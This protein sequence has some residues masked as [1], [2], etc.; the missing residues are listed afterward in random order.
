MKLAMTSYGKLDDPCVVLIHPFPFSSEMLA[1][2]A[3]VLAA[4][5]FRVI[6]PDLP[7]FGRTPLAQIAP[8]FEALGA[9]I[10]DLLDELQVKK[11][12]VG[13]V[14]LGGYVA[15]SVLRQFS[16]RV[17]GLLLVDTKA[18]ADSTEARENRLRIA[19]QM[20]EN[21]RLGLFAQQMLPNLISAESLAA[22]PGLEFAVTAHIEASDPLA[23][24]WMQEAM[25]MRPDSTAD[26]AKVQI[27]VLLLRGSAD[28]LCSPQDYQLMIDACPAAQF[29]ELVEIGHLPNLECPSELGE[30]L[31][32]FLSPHNL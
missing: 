2:S 22:R 10:V 30:E 23:I 15:L 26:L 6:V 18:S 25:A 9:A 13:G 32:S 20:R 4:H 3:S 8:N 28:L 19:Q 16:D 21:P 11:A 14:S 17:S 1:V 29:V 7:G 24:A 31:A 27:P 12:V 5:G